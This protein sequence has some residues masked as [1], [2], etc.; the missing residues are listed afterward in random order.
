AGI[1]PDAAG[2]LHQFDTANPAAPVF[3][4]PQMSV[5][6]VHAP[7][8][9]SLRWRPEITATDIQPARWFDPDAWRGLPNWSLEPPQ[10][11]MGE[12]APG[13]VQEILS[14][15]LSDVTQYADLFRALADLPVDSAEDWIAEIDA[16]VLPTRPFLAPENA[17]EWLRRWFNADTLPIWTQLR[18]LHDLPDAPGAKTATLNLR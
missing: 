7:P 4:L 5:P 1:L 14:L 18:A 12:R 2:N 3:T 9:I 16:D 10:P 15:P 13:E 11:L 8:S 6:Q 17:E